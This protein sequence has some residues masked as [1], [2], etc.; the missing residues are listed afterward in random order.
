MIKN[1]TNH[2]IANIYGQNKVSKS[3]STKL[4]SDNVAINTPISKQS[5]NINF[6]NAI[7]AYNSTKIRTTLSTKEE[8][9]KYNAVSS[10][11]DKKT[12]KTLSKYAKTEQ[13]KKLTEKNYSL[14]L[15]AQ[16]FI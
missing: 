3:N 7:A 14:L 1:I 15:W 2:S 12:K 10:I 8:N 11:L 9:E 16:D 13:K 4:A 5:A 6:G